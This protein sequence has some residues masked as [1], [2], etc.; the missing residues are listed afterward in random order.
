MTVRE[1]VD[2]V[3]ERMELL[4]APYA[5]KLP[6]RAQE[7]QEGAEVRDAHSEPVPETCT[8]RSRL[9]C[10]VDGRCNFT[11][12][13]FC[14]PEYCEDRQRQACLRE[15]MCG[16]DDVNAACGKLHVDPEDGEEDIF[17]DPQE[18]FV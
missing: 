12:N 1:R 10:T 4:L 15:D 17:F 2:N 5:V 14:A 13:G 11:N 9:N 6:F 8:D 3:R 16:W 7:V 18:E